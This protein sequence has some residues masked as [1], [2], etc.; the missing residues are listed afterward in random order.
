LY[1]AYMQAPYNYWIVGRKQPPPTESIGVKQAAAVWTSSQFLL[2]SGN[3]ERVQYMQP[4]QIQ[5]SSCFEAKDRGWRGKNSQHSCVADEGAGATS[6]QAMIISLFCNL[7]NSCYDGTNSKP[8]EQTDDGAA[9]KRWL[10]SSV[11]AEFP[12]DCELFD[13]QLRKRCGVFLLRVLYLFFC[14]IS[15]APSEKPLLKAVNTVN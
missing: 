6:G 2:P 11:S 1:G 15:V 14:T 7:K 9:F 4:G 13:W 8:L 10:E 12:L 3:Y 5:L